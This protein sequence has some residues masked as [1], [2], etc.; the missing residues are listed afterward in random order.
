MDAERERSLAQVTREQWDAK[1]AFWDEQI[2]DGNQTQLVLVGPAVEQLLDVQPDERVLDIACG[3]GVFARRLAA[4]GAR[5]VACDFSAAMLG[6][7]RARKS[8]HTDRI[9]YKLI[10]A[11]DESQF[12]ALGDSQFDGAIANQALHDIRDIEPLARA[13]PRLLKP[14]GRFVFSVPHP[15]FNFDGTTVGHEEPERQGAI[16]RQYYVK[17]FNYLRVPATASTGIVGEPVPHTQ[18]HRPLSTL[19]GTFFDQG[20]MLDALLEPSYGPEHVSKRPLGWANFK[21]IPPVLVAR[22]RLR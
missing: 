9:E 17:V 12:M 2:G 21:D 14:G 5:V 4:L 15:A 3:N 19:L 20:F 22:L 18:F 1:A 10:D 6:H 7:A 11:T 13:L 16:D 8:E